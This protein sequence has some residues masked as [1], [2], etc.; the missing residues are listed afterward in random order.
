MLGLDT[1]GLSSLKGGLITS[2]IV[3]KEFQRNNNLKKE[4]KKVQD[5]LIENQK[6]MLLELT[7]KEKFCLIYPNPHKEMF[8]F[9]YQQN[10]AKV[11][12]NQEDF[13]WYNLILD[14][15]IHEKG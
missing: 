1:K 3:D 4:T 10:R 13:H 8:K 7:S 11:T 12:M 5:Q 15:K 6:K 2:E 9:T 14:K